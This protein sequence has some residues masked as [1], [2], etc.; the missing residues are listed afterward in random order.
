MVLQS[1]SVLIA[2]LATAAVIVAPA[3]ARN[4]ASLQD[5]VGARGSSGQAALE[6]R[7]FTYI[8]GHEGKHAVH[9]YYW[10]HRDKNCIHVKTADGRYAKI[11]DATNE[12]CNH[13]SGGGGAET[14]VAGAVVGAVLLAALTH[15]SG[16]HGDE[17]H[18]NDPKHEEQYERGFSDGL[19]NVSYH[20][21]GK[22]DHYADGYQAGVEERNRNTKHHSG[23]GG[24]GHHVS[25]DGIEGRDPVWAI[26]EMS[27]RGFTNVDSFSSGNTLYGIYFN[28][29]SGQCV[30]MTNSRNKVEDVMELDYNPHCG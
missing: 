1:K 19:H 23:R 25:L 5:L 16:H 22:S 26:D 21:Y 20:N 12:D 11:A 28:Q 30:Q 3:M 17:Q 10:N 24:Y 7:G 29:A 18:F 15:K 27:A 2:S 14:A 8:T 13:S 9:T 6:D 4:A